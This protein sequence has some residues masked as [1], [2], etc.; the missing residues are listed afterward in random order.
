MNNIGFHLTR[1]N[2]LIR[3]MQTQ[4]ADSFADK[5]KIY[6]L[7]TEICLEAN[8]IRQECGGEDARRPIDSSVFSRI[9]SLMGIGGFK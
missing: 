7:A 4:A 5:K 9:L 1:L 3:T 8:Y 2:I 6:E